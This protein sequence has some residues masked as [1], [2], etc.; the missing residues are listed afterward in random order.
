MDGERQRQR[1]ME[2]HDG[3][4]STLVCFCERMQSSRSYCLLVWGT[5]KDRP[6]EKQF[7][8]VSL[9]SMLARFFLVQVQH[10]MFNES[11]TARSVS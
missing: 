3:S 11:E 5:S 8:C 6:H 9:H 1:N 10:A 7:P 4:N 2:E